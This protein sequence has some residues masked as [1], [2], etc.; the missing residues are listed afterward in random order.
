LRNA[1]QLIFIYIDFLEQ[2]FI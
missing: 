2:L 1:D